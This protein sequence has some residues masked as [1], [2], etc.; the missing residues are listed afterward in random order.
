M[1]MQRMQ[2]MV[3]DGGGWQKREGRERKKEEKEK[4]EQVRRGRLRGHL[5]VGHL[6][7]SSPHAPLHP[8]SRPPP[9]HP[10]HATRAP[11]TT[12]TPSSV[13]WAHLLADS[14][15]AQPAADLHTPPASVQRRGARARRRGGHTSH[16]ARKYSTISP[17]I[18]RARRQARNR[19]HI[20][21]RILLE[22]GTQAP[23][24]VHS[25]AEC[26]WGGGGPVG[27]RQQLVCRLHRRVG[28]WDDG[29]PCHPA[30]SHPPNQ[31]GPGR[32]VGDTHSSCW[33]C[34]VRGR[35]GVGAESP[36]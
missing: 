23:H 3:A 29:W 9:P 30:P 32:G 18:G 33:R 7:T 12:S 22:P 1:R 11:T 25:S 34:L 17:E 27:A 6:T 10:H 16:T 20:M 19:T 2:R 26:S 15:T 24:T 4:A 28:A 5:P 36:A 31:G 14:A 35:V 8:A 13:H 21:L